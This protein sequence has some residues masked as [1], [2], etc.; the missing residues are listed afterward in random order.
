MGKLNWDEKSEL[1]KSG[2]RDEKKTA[3]LIIIIHITYTYMYYEFEPNSDRRSEN[4]F[5]HTILK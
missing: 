4:A 5:K 2:E 3:E 1:T